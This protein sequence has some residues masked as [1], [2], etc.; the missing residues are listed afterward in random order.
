MSSNTAPEATATS[1]ADLD[2]AGFV[3][4]ARKWM[5]ECEFPGTDF[6]VRLDGQ[7]PYLQIEVSGTNA[8]RRARNGVARAQ[9][10]LSLHMTKSESFRQRSWP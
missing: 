9:W 4:Q 6:F 10:F 7:R 2:E 1:L 5:L 3:D 8:R